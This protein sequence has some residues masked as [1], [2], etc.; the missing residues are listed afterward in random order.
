M[1]LPLARI[2]RPN[3]TSESKGLEDIVMID[4]LV[5]AVPGVC[6]VQEA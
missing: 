6:A 5:C 4:R 1:V 2:S 3:E